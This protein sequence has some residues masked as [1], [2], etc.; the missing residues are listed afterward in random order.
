VSRTR[1][2]AGPRRWL[3]ALAL[4]FASLPVVAALPPLTDYERDFLEL[5]EAGDRLRIA[6]ARG[7][8]TTVLRAR[9]EVEL[10][11]FR[12]R[13]PGATGAAAA[14]AIAAQ[15]DDAS[16]ALAGPAAHDAVAPDCAPEAIRDQDRRALQHHLY[17]CYS[18]AAEAL[19]LDGAPVDRLAI[20]NAIARSDD[21]R[22]REQ[23]F[24]A[25]EP[26]FRSVTGDGRGP[27]PY[28]RLQPMVAEAWRSGDSPVA[29]N[30][31]ALDIPAD[32][33]EPWLVSILEAWRDLDPA[34]DLEPWD[35]EY[36]GSTVER[37][38]GARVPRESFERIN[39]QYHASLGAD[40]AALNIHYDLAPR[41]GKTA[42]A[43][44]DFGARPRLRSDGS[45][46][47]GEPWVFAS[48][49]SGGIGNLN[50]LLHET[51]HAIHIAAIR[52][53]P[54]FAD[55]PDSDALTEAIA[56]IFSLEIFE[57]AWQQRWLGAAAPLAGNLKGRYSGIAMDVAWGLFELRVY[58]DP[59]RDPNAVWTDITSRYLHVR[60]H[61]EL[62]WWARRG[63][64]VDSPGYM[65]NY[66][67]GAILAADLRARA[68]ELRGAPSEPDPGY[69][70]WLAERVLRFGLERSSAQVLR[71]FLGRPPDPAAL[72]ADMRRR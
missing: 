43:F 44:T 36:A 24:G 22:R 18:R 38:L 52:T 72:L 59:A 37:R 53:T 65:M 23:L 47:P 31:A 35:Y 32:R 1:D 12:A 56:E 27:N 13:D 39:A 21:A 45:W 57:P 16:A 6:A 20:L 48:Y 70:P 46:S 40:L 9:H 71:D 66:A 61:A 67:L 42:V 28:R 62:A 25:L 51:G 11:A 60:P 10:A 64:L 63:Q 30:L 55:W 3:L 49:S 17:A 7:E 2:R 34:A 15:L 8:D 33:L 5:R 69:Y 14:R 29:R 50:E 41:P 4:A 26:L 58:A 68:R 54:A 19:Q